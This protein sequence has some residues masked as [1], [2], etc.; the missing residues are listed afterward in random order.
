MPA[1]SAANARQ[2]SI[3]S[4]LIGFRHHRNLLPS[5]PSHSSTVLNCFCKIHSTCSPTPPSTAAPSCFTRNGRNTCHSRFSSSVGQH[6]VAGAFECEPCG[7][8]QRS[9]LFEPKV[10]G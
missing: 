2:I 8:A 5:G 6:V 1:C 10:P 3:N 9:Q 4:A 7:L